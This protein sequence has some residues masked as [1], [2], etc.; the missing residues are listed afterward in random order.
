M[1]YTEEHLEFLRD[2]YQSMLVPEL[3]R[4]FNKRFGTDQ[5][6]GQI[7]STL[8]NHGIR[9]GRHCGKVPWGLR[10]F[11]PDQDS[12]LRDNYPRYSLRDL[13]GELNRQFGTVKTASQVKAYTHNHGIT[14]GRSG[15]FQ[16]GQKA[17]NLGVKGYM[18]AN[19]TSFSK[20]T[21]PHNK[22]RLWTERIGKDGY[23]EISVPERNPHTGHPTRFK[24]KHVWLWECANGKVPRGHAVIFI[25]GD[26]G[27]FD[28]SNLMMVTRNELLL[29]NLHKY[30]VQPV[31][32][33]PALMALIKLEAGAGFRTTGRMP[34]AGRKKGTLNKTVTGSPP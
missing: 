19:R 33:R 26:K 28:L 8:K 20:G 14:S 3:T 24:H 10:L 9:C 12:F 6:P 11:T 32:V 2:G 34:G 13:T 1:R 17:W 30:W 5:Q 21:R 27:N 31:E 23:I 22:K 29:M 15:Q 7:R 4:A 18:G 25:D 16:K